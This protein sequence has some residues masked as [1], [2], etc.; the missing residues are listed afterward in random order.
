MRPDSTLHDVTAALSAHNSLCLKGLNENYML[1][2]MCRP[3]TNGDFVPF[4]TRYSYCL[5]KNFNAEITTRNV[6]IL[7]LIN[8]CLNFSVN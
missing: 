5:L 8:N 2:A 7:I 4:K 1:D 3:D 6:R